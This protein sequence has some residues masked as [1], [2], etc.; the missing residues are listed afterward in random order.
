MTLSLSLPP[1]LLTELASGRR[2]ARRSQFDQLP[3]DSSGKTT[4]SNW[5]HVQLTLDV[6]HP[7]RERELGVGLFRP[8][9]YV[10]TKCYARV[11]LSRMIVRAG[12]IKTKSEYSSEW[13]CWAR[14]HCHC[15][16]NKMSNCSS[17]IQ[18]WSWI[19]SFQDRIIPRPMG[20]YSE[21]QSVQS[22]KI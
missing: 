19:L 14:M 10:P 1:S 4:A 17:R 18:T 11:D 13:H 21:S 22:V 12:I 8:E 16:Q 20:Q 7:S 6:N 15:C 3:A 5:K 9:V 2:Q